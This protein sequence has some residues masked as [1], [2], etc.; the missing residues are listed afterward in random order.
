VIDEVQKAPK[1]LDQIHYEIEKRQ[2]KF[3]LTGSSA[4]KLRRGGANLLAGR[5]LMNH[6]YPLTHRELAADFVLQDVLQWGSLPEIFSA[7]SD[8]VRQEYLKT[9]VDSYLKEEILQ[10]QLVRN[11]VPFR[12]FLPVAAQMNGKIL[13]FS[14]MA[15]DLGVDWSTVKNYY[16]ILEDTWLGFNLPIY[17]RSLRK[18]QLKGQKFYLFD[19]GVQRALE[20]NLK[21]PVGRTFKH[22]CGNTSTLTHAPCGPKHTRFGSHPCLSIGIIA[23]RQAERGFRLYFDGIITRS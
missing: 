19:L 15:K 13:N 4:R 12:K 7:P 14:S 16:Q 11:V 22:R 3:A 20:R 9:Y 18:Q 21:V 6:L 23:T 5:A 17:H 1:L 10:E 2:I 8:L